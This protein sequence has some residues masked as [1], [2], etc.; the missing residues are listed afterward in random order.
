M[1]NYM[2][3]YQNFKNWNKKKIFFNQKRI[4]DKINH[5]ILKNSAKIIHILKNNN[6]KN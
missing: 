6:N 3:L 4:S 2:L 5:K 1:I